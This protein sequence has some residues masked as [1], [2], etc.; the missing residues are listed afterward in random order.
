MSTPTT[1]ATT[2]S[3]N[4][5]PASTLPVRI[6]SHGQPLIGVLHLPSGPGPH[7]VVVLLHGFPG[8]ER[9]FDLA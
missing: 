2:S 8:Y 4:T 3:V 9:G 5:P 7:P 6:D 1:T